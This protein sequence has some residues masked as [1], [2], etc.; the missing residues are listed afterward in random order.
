MGGDKV[1]ALMRAELVSQTG[2]RSHAFRG[3]SPIIR[4]HELSQTMTLTFASHIE[5]AEEMTRG[6]GSRRSSRPHPLAP[7]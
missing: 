1:E 2:F 6:S 5:F 7:V 3:I 4:Y